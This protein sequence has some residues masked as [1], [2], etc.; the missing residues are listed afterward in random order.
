MADPDRPGAGMGGRHP[1]HSPGEF[2]GGDVRFER[3]RRKP[4]AVSKDQP[5]PLA[6]PGQCLGDAGDPREDHVRIEI[7]RTEAEPADEIEL[8]GNFRDH[9]R[10]DA[11]LVKRLG[12]AVERAVF[13]HEAGH[14]FGCQD[15]PPADPGP[16]AV[17][18]RVE[19]RTER[20]LTPD[21]LGQSV[22]EKRPRPHHPHIADKPGIQAAQDGI[23]RPRARPEVIR[24][25]DQMG[26]Q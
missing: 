26:F 21:Q 22:A 14:V 1:G 23:V 5:F 2:A 9:F 15:R 11:P 19:P 8:G 18:R 3:K 17:E 7:A 20:I 16:F 6:K 25:R 13:P 10:H 12:V 24:T 4:R